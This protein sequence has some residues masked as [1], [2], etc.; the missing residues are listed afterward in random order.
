ME[1]EGMDKKTVMKG[2]GRQTQARQGKAM[3]G[4]GN[5]KREGTGM[6]WNGKEGQ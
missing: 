2:H 6:E 1:G 4:K 3:K 5:N